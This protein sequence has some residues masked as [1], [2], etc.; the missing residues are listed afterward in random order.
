MIIYSVYKIVNTTNGKIYVGYTKNFSKRLNEHK[1]YSKR[2]NTKFYRAITKYGWHNFTH[3]IICQSLSESDI[4]Q[5]EI[6]FISE[7]NSYKKGYNSTIGGD[8]S[9]PVNDITKAKMSLA[10]TGKFQA[11]DKN[12]NY[13][14]ISKDDPRYISG[15]LVGINKG[16]KASDSTKKL[17]SER[18]MGNKHLLGHK[19]TEETKQKI[20]ESLKKHQPILLAS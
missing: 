8:G 17:M 14:L 11:K 2:N 19:H 3:E 1:Q 20:K 5:L 16:K 9:G 10:K 4:K 18:R 6:Y 15:E 13:F 12:N 7:Y